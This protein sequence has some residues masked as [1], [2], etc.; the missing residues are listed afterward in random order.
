MRGCLN[1]YW[2]TTILFYSY[3]IVLIMEN[4]I[5]TNNSKPENSCESPFSFRSVSCS[6]VPA[7]FARFL[8][9]KMW[10]LIQYPILF[11]NY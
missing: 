11:P 3:L 8:P 4:L 2:F 6:F 10:Q 9:K 5:N 1:N 7:M